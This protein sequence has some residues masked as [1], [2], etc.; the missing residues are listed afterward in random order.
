MQK[1]IKNIKYNEYRIG[2]RKQTAVMLV[3]IFFQ[4]QR[5]FGSR[6]MCG[7]T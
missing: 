3:Q 5:K 2:K 4:Q 6:H 1:A 7:A